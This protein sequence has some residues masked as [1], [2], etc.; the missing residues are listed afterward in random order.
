LACRVSTS[1]LLVVYCVVVM[2]KRY[3][4]SLRAEGREE[5]SSRSAWARD[6]PRDLRACIFGLDMSRE[7]A[8]TAYRWDSSGSERT[9]WA[10][11]L[12]WLPVAPKTARRDLDMVDV[13]V[14]KS[15]W[16]LCY[17]W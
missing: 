13:D 3:E 8:R 5:G 12:P 10:V 14:W 7:T 16:D 6:A 1:R 4:T 15:C 17:R 2:K 9:K 11:E